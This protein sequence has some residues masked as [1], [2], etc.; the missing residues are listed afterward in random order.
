M[1]DDQPFVMVWEN[2]D[3]DTWVE[4]ADA[5]T[6]A[7]AGAAVVRQNGGAYAATGRGR[8][9]TQDCE[10]SPTHGEDDR[11]AHPL[12]GCIDHPGTA[13]VVRNGV[14]CWG[15]ESFGDLLSGRP[16]WNR[17]T[18][19]DIEAAVADG[20]TVYLPDGW[21]IEDGHVREG[22]PVVVYEAPSEPMFP[23]PEA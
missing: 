18:V 22:A 23:E 16:E 7:E 13:C 9:N 10:C 20:Q 12:D 14:D 15:F 8:I 2:E 3:G 5:A 21:Y 11:T 19:A 4:V 6:E 17:F 1:S